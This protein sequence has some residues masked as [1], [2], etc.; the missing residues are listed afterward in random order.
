VGRFNNT[1]DDVTQPLE[2]KHQNSGERITLDSSGLKTQKIDD[3]RLYAGAFSGTN[4]DARLV[5]C[6]SA[7]PAGATVF[8]ERDTYSQ[9][10]TVNQSATLI[11]QGT[12]FDG[13]EFQGT[14]TMTLA[15]ASTLKGIRCL[16]DAI[17]IV[18]NAPSCLL[19]NISGFGVVGSKSVISVDDSS[20][21]LIG[22]RGLKV[23][24]DSNSDRCVVNSSTRL[25]IVDNGS[26]NIIGSN[27]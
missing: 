13:T 5:N 1:A 12:V 21:R 24:L 15:A 25:N 27:A 23:E 10:I 6:L 22:L 26:N 20:A 7:A 19:Q 3:D 14:M 11:G 18:V 4:A 16:G 2:I 17:D 8:L 9:N